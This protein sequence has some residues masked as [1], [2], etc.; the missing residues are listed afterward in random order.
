MKTNKLAL[1][2]QLYLAAHATKLLQ[3]AR[4]GQDRGCAAATCAA[5]L[6]L[7][8]TEVDLPLRLFTDHRVYAPS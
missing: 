5:H 8:S 7:G 2:V 1:I 3:H 6:G 4:T